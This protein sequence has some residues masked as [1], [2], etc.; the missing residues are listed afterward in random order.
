MSALEVG[1]ACFFSFSAGAGL[2]TI[3]WI[4]DRYRR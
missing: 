4:I 2:I 3:C 1:A